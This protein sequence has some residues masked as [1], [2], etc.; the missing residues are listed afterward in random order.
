MKSAGSCLAMAANSEAAPPALWM[1]AHMQELL[2]SLAGQISGAA[3]ALALE[4][5][6]PYAGE[7]G[8][9]ESKLVEWVRKLAEMAR[10]K[11]RSTQLQAALL[12]RQTFRG[13]GLPALPRV[14]VAAVGVLLALVRQAE[15]SWDCA[16][17]AISALSALEQGLWRL[18]ADAGG[19]REAAQLLGR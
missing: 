10:S 11:D 15:R 19:H 8:D 9:G 13:C 12:L 6:K 18:G 1:G 2:P 3:I 5:Y 16:A 14:Q 4:D 17:M 7:G